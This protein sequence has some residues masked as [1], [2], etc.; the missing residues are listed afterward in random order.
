MNPFIEAIVFVLIVVVLPI[1]FHRRIPSYIRACLL[2]GI[3]GT[4]VIVL[5]G[6]LQYVLEILVAFS[7]LLF[8]S[9]LIGLPFMRRRRQQRTPQHRGNEND[10]SH[11]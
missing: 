6:R 5:L 1:Q 11:A 8:V 9:A 10:N 3:V 7:L 2:S 4:V